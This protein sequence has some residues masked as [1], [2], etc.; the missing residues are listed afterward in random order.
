MFLPQQ[1]SLEA[2]YAQK[3]SITCNAPFF[4]FPG[5]ILEQR[6]SRTS[7]L[8]KCTFQEYSIQRPEMPVVLERRRCEPTFRGVPTA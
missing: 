7:L 6:S 1:V 8:E 4:C 2:L 5:R 3:T